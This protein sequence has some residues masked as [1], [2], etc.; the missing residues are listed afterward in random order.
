MAADPLESLLKLR[1]LEVDDARRS[2]ADSQAVERAA[3]DAAE[4][5]I[6]ALADEADAATRLQADD[7]AVD[8]FAAWL[9]VGRAAQETAETALLT[10]KAH[11]AAARAALALSRAALRAVEVLIAE[12]AAER[13]AAMQQQEQHRLDEIGGRPAAA[14]GDES[15]GVKPA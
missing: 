10:A 2:L 7:A 4:D 14:A 3:S 9:P 11:S 1:R 8:A 15:Q 13:Q 5:A 6:R 12:H